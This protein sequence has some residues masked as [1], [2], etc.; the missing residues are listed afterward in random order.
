MQVIKAVRTSPFVFDNATATT[1]ITINTIATKAVLR[2]YD[3]NATTLNIPGEI[4]TVVNGLGFCIDFDDVLKDANDAYTKIKEDAAAAK[5]I[6]LRSK[7][8]S[9]PVAKAFNEAKKCAH[10]DLTVSISATE[11]GWINS[12][13]QNEL[14][15]KVKLNGY[16]DACSISYSDK[17]FVGRSFY[18]SCT[19][20]VWLVDFGYRFKKS[21]VRYSSIQNAIKAIDSYLRT[22]LA[23]SIEVANTKLTK[24]SKRLRLV[25]FAMTEFSYFAD[26]MD[27]KLGYDQS[28]N[29]IKIILPTN[30]IE[31]KIWDFEST[32]HPVTYTLAGISKLTKEQVLII[33]NTIK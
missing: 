19:N 12:T 9:S 20:K 30:N 31:L 33:L 7:Y 6:T 14:T 10:K 32:V 15:L 8:N 25:K 2:F 3:G 18:G 5:L 28:V 26:M 24:E 29:A 11:E 4:E 22:A 21:N 1:E 17:V 23:N 27:T 16:D 13:Y